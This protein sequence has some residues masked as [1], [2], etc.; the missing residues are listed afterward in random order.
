MSF[1]LILHVSFTSEGRITKLK[2]IKFSMRTILQVFL[3]SIIQ[4]IFHL[5]V[6]FF[7]SRILLL[8]V[9]SDTCSNNACIEIL[10]QT[11]QLLIMLKIL[12]RMIYNILN[13]KGKL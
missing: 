4:N 11:P 5:I 13:Y 6:T 7:F 1:I 8:I 2:S 9:T 12:E 10:T 3:I